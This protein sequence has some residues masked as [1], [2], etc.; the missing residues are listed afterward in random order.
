MVVDANVLLSAFF[1]DESQ[2]HAHALVRDHVA[3]R[4]ILKAPALLHYELCN[5]IWVAERRARIQREQAD[6]IIHALDGLKINLVTQEW[7]EM[8]PL[9]RQFQCGAYDAA[10][11]SL[12]QEEGEPLI[13]GDKRLY[14]AVHSH[15]DWVLWIGDYGNTT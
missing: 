10:Y 15:L 11:L 14:Q 9:A 3:G 13:T 8:L 6:Q 4:V 5:A 7:G 1:P 2:T 12:A